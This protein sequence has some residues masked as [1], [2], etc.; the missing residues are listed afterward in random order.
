MLS[1]LICGPS[2]HFLLHSV[3]PI[4]YL[5]FFLPVALWCCYLHSSSPIE[6]RVLFMLIHLTGVS[7]PLFKF[8]SSYQVSHLFSTGVLSEFD[9][10]CSLFISFQPECLHLLLVHCNPFLMSVNLQG[11]R[12]VPCSSF[13]T[14]CFQPRSAPLYSLLK[15]LWF[16]SFVKE[17]T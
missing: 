14:E 7:C 8:F 10:S 6:D 15:V 4:I 16:H 12:N 2:W 13:L 9:L 17:A 11:S 5:L 1:K 3:I